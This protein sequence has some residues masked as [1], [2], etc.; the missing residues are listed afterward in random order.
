MQFLS[1]LGYVRGATSLG[2]TIM[3][4]L[5]IWFYGPSIR[6]DRYVPFERADVRI[7]AIAVLGVVV[8]GVFIVRWLRRRRAAAALET[9]MTS[10]QA[11]DGEV[12]T[13]R[14]RD[15]LVTLKKSRGDAGDYLYSIPWYDHHRPARCGED[16]RAG[17][18][19]A[20]VPAD[21]VGRQGRRRGH[22]R[23]ALLRLVVRRG[24]RPSSTP[25]GATPRRTAARKGRAR[26][27]STARAGSPSST[28][29]ARTGRGSRSTA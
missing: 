27:T 25:R 12:L 6:I 19:R 1:Y 20:Q 11:D 13:E 10:P 24:C 15:A 22:R 29:C 3:L 8:L 4:A 5:V 2:G 23:H 7:A 28:C 21:V 9:A 18:L 14:M 16:H 26:R 17:Q